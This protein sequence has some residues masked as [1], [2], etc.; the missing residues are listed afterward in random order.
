MYTNGQSP[1]PQATEGG[2]LWPRPQCQPHCQPQLGRLPDS[3][4]FPCWPSSA[5]G[6]RLSGIG[7][8]RMLVLALRAPG[9]LWG[10]SHLYEG[11]SAGPRGS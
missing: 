8:T 5:F 11:S 10:P 3:P 4:S 7:G 1:V 6:V 9:A 2:Q